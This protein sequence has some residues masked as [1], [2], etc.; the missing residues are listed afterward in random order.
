MWPVI[1]ILDFLEDLCFININVLPMCGFF[2]LSLCYLTWDYDIQFLQLR[3]EVL[4][5]IVIF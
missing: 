1:T 4:M 5:L 2:S 3:I